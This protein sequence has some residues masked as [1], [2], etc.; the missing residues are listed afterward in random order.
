MGL[1]LDPEEGRRNSCELRR[2][3]LGERSHRTSDSRARME[4]LR[5][6]EMYK[7]VGIQQRVSILDCVAP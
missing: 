2:G 6:G 4:M 5:V 3:L 1:D 7:E